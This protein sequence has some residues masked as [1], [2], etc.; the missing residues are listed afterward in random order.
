MKLGLKVLIAGA[1]AA[2]LLVPVAAATAGNGNGPPA[3]A[4]GGSGGAKENGKPAWAGQGQAKKAEKAAL[5]AA[6]ESDAD[7]PKHDNPAW[8]CKFEREQM[9]TEAFAENYGS[10][11]NKANAFGQCVAQEAQDR[12]GVTG[13]EEE[14]PEPGAEEPTTPEEPMG[15]DGLA[16]LQAFFHALRQLMVF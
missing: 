15:E 5:R 2:A 9:G 14:T 1:L 4:G 13:G 10:N 16:A 12:D 11:E 3:W 7:A 8:V 6:S